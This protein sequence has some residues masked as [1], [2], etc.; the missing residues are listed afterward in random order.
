MQHGKRTESQLLPLAERC[1]LWYWLP[2]LPSV[3]QSLASLYW[4]E[5]LTLLGHTDDCGKI[6][7]GK[8]LHL[9]LWLVGIFQSEH[10]NAR[11]RDTAISLYL[12]AAFSCRDNQ[13]THWLLY[14]CCA[15]LS[16]TMAYPSRVYLESSFLFSSRS[17]GMRRRSGAPL[18]PIVCVPHHQSLLLTPLSRNPR[19][20]FHP[21]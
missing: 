13:L 15:Y 8:N 19:W 7:L 5:R 4:C 20:R 14:F 2:F 10:I 17:S 11:D 16:L 3:W 18:Q 21:T 9:D 12:N 1:L 6:T